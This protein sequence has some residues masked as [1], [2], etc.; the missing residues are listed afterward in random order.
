MFITD[1]RV[2]IFLYNINININKKMP[3]SNILTVDP[4]YNLTANDIDDN[5]PIYNKHKRN[6]MLYKT[7]QN[8]IKFLTK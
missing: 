1:I 4:I 6:M 5:I 8:V 7:K 2:N 3:I